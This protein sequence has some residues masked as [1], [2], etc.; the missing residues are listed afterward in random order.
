MDRYIKISSQDRDVSNLTNLNNDIYNTVFT[1]TFIITGIIDL[2]MFYLGKFCNKNRC[3]L[4]KI[5][6]DKGPLQQICEFLLISI[7]K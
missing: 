5:R 6:R 4:S 1:L 2:K 7:E 3:F